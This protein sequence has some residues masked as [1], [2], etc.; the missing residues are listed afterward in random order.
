MQTNTVSPQA[1]L[2][3][4]RYYRWWAAS[5]PT[6]HSL[7]SEA[8]IACCL[9]SKGRRSSPGDYSCPI[10]NPVRNP[11]APNRNLYSYECINIV[12]NCVDSI[13][14]YSTGTLCLLR[15]TALQEGQCDGDGCTQRRVYPGRRVADITKL[16]VRVAL[17]DA[18]TKRHNFA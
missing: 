11:V 13:L 2:S 5:R 6:S 15:Q 10:A 4:T 7:K 14:R 3:W 1:L 16:R 18:V 8:F 12:Q 17:L 9:P